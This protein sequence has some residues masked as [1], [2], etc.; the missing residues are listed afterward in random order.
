MELFPAAVFN[1]SRT[2]RARRPRDAAAGRSV[3]SLPLTVRRAAA[4]HD[5]PAA[6]RR[7]QAADAGYPS[8]VVHILAR[9]DTARHDDDAIVLVAESKRDGS[10]LASMRIR[11][12]RHR[13]LGIEESV[14]LPRH[15]QGKRL[16]EVAW[17]GNTQADELARAAL[18]KACFLVCQAN[19]V[20]YAVVVGHS[21]I[22]RQCRRLLFTDLFAADA[23]SLLRHAGNVRHRVMA[24]R[25]ANLQQRWDAARHPLH[26]FFFN[27][28][29]PDIDTGP[30]PST[31]AFPAPA[32]RPPGQVLLP[33]R[34]EMAFA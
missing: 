10:P 30:R 26:N 8:A 34:R 27:T 11:F 14:V 16:A 29:H 32:P 23:P 21:L 25:I 13:P 9:P 3:E 20:D 31:P 7:R 6:A 2:P 5:L 19:A 22:A 1:P 17:L 33:V 28:H 15:L 24:C 18:I 4:G 12:N